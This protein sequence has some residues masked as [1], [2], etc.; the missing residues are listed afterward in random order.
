MI[1]W[2]RVDEP[3]TLAGAVEGHQRVRSQPLG[4]CLGVDFFVEAWLVPLKTPPWRTG[5]FVTVQ[6]GMGRVMVSDRL[7]FKVTIQLNSSADT[8]PV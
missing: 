2:L 3:H 6:Q 1:T 7:G 8:Q 5:D 4:S